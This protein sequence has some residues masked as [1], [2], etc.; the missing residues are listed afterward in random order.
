MIHD[1]GE[2]IITV[3]IKVTNNIVEGHTVQPKLTLGWAEGEKGR[4]NR[5]YG[6]R[7]REVLGCGELLRQDPSWGREGGN[8]NPGDQFPVAEIEVW[9]PQT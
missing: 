8:L 5:P 2:A 9:T 3:W 6:W 1:D 4:R 7:S